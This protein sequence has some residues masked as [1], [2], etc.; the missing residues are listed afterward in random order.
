M[1]PKGDREYTEGEK[2]RLTRFP[3]LARLSR[4]WNWSQYER[5]FPVF[6][7]NRR[8][9]A[10]MT[11]T[12]LDD[13]K[14]HIKDPG[15]RKLL[16]PDYPVGGKRILFADDYYPTLTRDNVD[17]V[18]SQIDHVTADGVVTSDGESHPFDALILATGFD[19]TSFLLPMKIEGLTG[20]SLRDDWQDEPVAYMGMTVS[21]FP[22]FFMMYGPNTNLGHN[23]IIFMIECQ[24][25]HIV[26]TVRQIFDQQIGS[27]DLRADVMKAY[28]ERIQEEL[29]GSSW[30]TTDHS[31]YK[32]E[33][34][35][36]TNNWS[37]TSIRYWWMTRRPDLS[38]YD[39]VPLSALTRDEAASDERLAQTG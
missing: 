16:T 17:L 13:M 8:S 30:A 24:A 15:L 34:G 38:V 11:K 3:W 28:N 21:G 10:A 32:N 7:Q 36:I 37:G 27:I 1:V 14:E 4:W 33:A 6:R 9:A 35:R 19:S 25:N 5:T 12:S 29:A 2:R 39:Q 26:A 20:R 18:T 31:W 22:N 23:S